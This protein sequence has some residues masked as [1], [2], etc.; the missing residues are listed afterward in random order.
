MPWVVGRFLPPLL[1]GARTGRYRNGRVR[2]LRHRIS[3][4]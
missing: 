1:L 2:L 3:H 4:F